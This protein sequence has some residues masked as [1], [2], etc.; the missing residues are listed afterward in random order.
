DK[1]NINSQLEH[2]QSKYVGTGHADITK[3]EWLVNQHRDSSALYVAQPG[4]VSYFAIAE[5]ETA[6]RTR[7]NLLERMLQPCGPPPP[8]AEEDVMEEEED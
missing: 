3:Y 6:A 8:K 5:G 2:L 4:L 7:M 1:I